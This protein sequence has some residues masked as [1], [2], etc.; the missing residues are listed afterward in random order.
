MMGQWHFRRKRPGEA[1]REPIQGEFFAA[2][3]IDRPGQ[4]LVREGIQNALDAARSNGHGERQQPV[5]V[6]IFL[7]GPSDSAPSAVAQRY[8]ETT[9]DHF[10]ADKSGLMPELLPDPAQSCRFLLFEDFGTEG[11][12][13]DTSTPFRPKE[14]TRNHF[15]YFVRAEGQT[16]KESKHRGSWGV[17]KHVFF[18]CSRISTIFAVTARADDG[19][20]LLI[21]KTVL[22]S[23]WLGEHHYQDGYYGIA[24]LDDGLVMPLTDPAEISAFCSA[25]RIE[26]GN[27][28]GLSIVVPWPDEEVSEQAL[29]E[30]V[31][32]DYYF[33][34]LD[35]QLEV[36]VETPSIRKAI[37]AESLISEL[38]SCGDEFAEEV[39][40]SIRLAQWARD[41]AS[42][43][44][45]V[46]G[47]PPTSES[48]HW[49]KSL[50]SSEQLT[51]LRRRI[52]QRERVSL[53]ARITLRPKNAD[54][55]E[56][57]FDV[58]L[59]RDET[60]TSGRPSFIREGIIIAD[61]KASRTRGIRAI[62]IADDRPLAAFLRAAEN[63]SHTT[64]D[65]DRVKDLYTYA[66]A[67]LDFVRNSVR[68]IT[69]IVSEEEQTEDRSVLLDVFSIP[70]TPDDEDALLAQAS[71]PKTRKR[72]ESGAPE[73]KLIPRPRRFR[74]SRAQGGFS[75]LPGDPDVGPPQ[76]LDVRVA[77]VVR[78]GSALKKY[79][80]ADFEVE[81]PPIEFTPEPAGVI[82]L[83][84]AGNRIRFAI[85]QRDFSLHVTGFDKN[86]D[87][88]VRAT[89]REESSDGDS[90]S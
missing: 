14:A 70:A 51:E 22:K 1:N 15:Y 33:P 52:E 6:R 16:D 76:Q 35:R 79:D 75:I 2:E 57:F 56:S 29:W 19:R 3:A 17:G 47:L 82:I 24:P 71:R 21:G 31:I 25:F 50:F 58:Y 61:V 26:R 38:D 18:R 48:P 69:R 65:K 44:R 86:R 13:G 45:I 39:G 55:E 74:I 77:Y 63:P 8:I 34:I 67:T 60:D 43:A 40:P 81:R 72:K 84:R 68:E 49:G 83:E 80:P 36:I 32:R 46:L 41:V 27:E 78:R 42:D 53:R 20:R 4:S 9:W 87:L 28:S 37:D 59:E 66:P 7:S 54:A 62:V 89:P 90:T 64:W 73:I 23:H 12:I 11:L 85:Q 10:R 30:S 88:Y 5:M